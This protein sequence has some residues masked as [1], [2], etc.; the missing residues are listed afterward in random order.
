MTNRLNSETSSRDNGTQNHEQNLSFGY[1]EPTVIARHPP[2]H[3]GTYAL[4]ALVGG[5]PILPDMRYLSAVTR[6]IERGQ[7]RRPQGW[8]G[9]GVGVSSCFWV[10]EGQDSQ[11]DAMAGLIACGLHCLQGVES[12]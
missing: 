2:A 7:G 8:P 3:I 6:V 4:A 10:I 9:E 1:S 12:V 5:P 11:D